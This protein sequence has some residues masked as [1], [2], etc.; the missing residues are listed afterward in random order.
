[1]Y[2]LKAIKSFIPQNIWKDQT[3]IF[4]NNSIYFYLLSLSHQKFRPTWKNDPINVNTCQ[5]VSP[6]FWLDKI[7][8][9]FDKYNWGNSILELPAAARIIANK[10]FPNFPVESPI[11]WEMFRDIR[12][13]AKQ[14]T[15]EITG[16]ALVDDS[17][18]AVDVQQKDSSYTVKLASGNQL[19]FGKET[20][21]INWW[22]QLVLHEDPKL[23]QRSHLEL[24]QLHPDEAP[25][26][27]IVF[28]SGLSVEWMAAHFPKTQIIAVK[29]PNQKLPEN[30][31]I[32]ISDLRNLTVFN[33]NEIAY[34]ISDD[35]KNLF[36]LDKNTKKEYDA[37]FYQSMGFTTFPKIL[38][39]VPAGKKLNLHTTL[40]IR[41]VAPKTLPTGG[42]LES[43]MRWHLL[44]ETL[45]W[46]FEPLAYHDGSGFPEVIRENMRIAGIEIKAAFFNKL[47]EII[48]NLDEST[49]HDIID[50]FMKAFQVQTPTQKESDQFKLQLTSLLERFKNKND[51]LPSW[52]KSSVQKSM[53][54][55]RYYSTYAGQCNQSSQSQSEQKKDNQRLRKILED[56]LKKYWDPQPIQIPFQETLKNNTKRIL[57]DG[58]ELESSLKKMDDVQKLT[59]Y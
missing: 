15:K 57:T 41:W 45:D 43:V 40:D 11:T 24:Y 12:N 28:G 17:P 52:K 56:I 33:S 58:S 13:E 34:D 14:L 23:I 6:P 25:R 4:G 32:K 44:A 38:E 21:F 27:V 26:Q 50:I 53:E 16:V 36:I 29:L 20:F 37:P 22:R 1:M 2:S 55:K 39:S 46:T 31:R 48:C 42:L 9:W 5:I 54:P 3:V 51:V 59:K 18:I 8:P 10:K 49:N 47:D 19:S 35:G 7:H 30:P